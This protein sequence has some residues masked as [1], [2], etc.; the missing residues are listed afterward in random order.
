M[1]PILTV[2]GWDGSIYWSSSVA[3]D[4]NR[5]TLANSLAQYAYAHGF[6]GL[7]FEY[8]HLFFHS[9][10]THRLLAGNTLASRV[11]VVTSSAPKTAQTSSLSCRKCV[12]LPP[13][14]LSLLQPASFLG[15][16]ALVLH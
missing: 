4:Q 14:S 7:D 11:S 5:S 12:R 6:T 13:I 8:V 10:L 3:T 15:L 9:H 2:G 16:I 1:K